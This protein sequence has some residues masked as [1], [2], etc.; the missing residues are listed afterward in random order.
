MECQQIFFIPHLVT[1]DRGAGFCERGRRGGVGAQTGGGLQ[2]GCG[3]DRRSGSALYLAFPAV[4]ATPAVWWWWRRRR[5]RRRRRQRWR[6]QRWRR[7]DDARKPAS[8]P[9]LPASPLFESPPQLTGRTCP[10]PKS[11]PIDEQK[12]PRRNTALPAVGIAPIP[13]GARARAAQAF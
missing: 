7:L 5:R 12:R 6:R 8:L 4:A 3:H 9:V 2:G 13:L 1:N 11:S 10:R